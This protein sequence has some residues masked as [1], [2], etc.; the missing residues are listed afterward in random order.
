MNREY[1]A[2][3]LQCLSDRRGAVFVP[4]EFSL[5]D[6]LGVI[7]VVGLALGWGIDHWRAARAQAT[8]SSELT[9]VRA[10]AEEARSRDWLMNEQLRK[11]RETLVA[12]LREEER[13]SARLR[14]EFAELAAEAR[15][16][17]A[18]RYTAGRER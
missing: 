9:A 14:L 15:P 4:F 16:E 18:A 7:V 2:L 5:R 11:D 3:D 1:S 10:A 12:R 13:T 6:C 17:P 8:I